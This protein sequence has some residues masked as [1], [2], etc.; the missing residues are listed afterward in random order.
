MGAE[1]GYRR[2]DE[3]VDMHL[4]V[5]LKVPFSMKVPYYVTVTETGTTLM[6]PL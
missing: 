2:L 6:V 3:G 4:K 1:T 5:L